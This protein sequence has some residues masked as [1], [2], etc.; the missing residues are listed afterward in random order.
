MLTGEQPEYNK[1]V[2]VPERIIPV[3]DLSHKEG[4]W[5]AWQLATRL[6]YLDLTYGPV[7]GGRMTEGTL[8]L[9]WWW[10]RYLRWQFNYGYALIEGGATPGRV[11]ILQ[12]RVQLMY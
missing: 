12:T 6:S 2:G 3:H 9:N 7:E 1:G 4:T 11:Q 8:G 5:G 10:N